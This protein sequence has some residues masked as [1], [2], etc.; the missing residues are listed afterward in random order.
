M[1]FFR[2]PIITNLDVE[3][4]KSKMSL[5]ELSGKIGNIIATLSILKRGK[6]RAVRFSTLDL[7]CSELKCEPSGL[8]EFNKKKE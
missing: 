4:T 7:I 1:I 5:T 6:V 2:M 8:F 3:H